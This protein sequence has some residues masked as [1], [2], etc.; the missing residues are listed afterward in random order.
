MSAFA[1]GAS[2]SIN[3]TIREVVGVRLGHVG[4]TGPLRSKLHG[5]LLREYDRLAE[6]WFRIGFRRGHKEARREFGRKGVVPKIL[7][8]KT[9]MKFSRG[10]SKAVRLVSV[11]K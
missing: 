10:A 7:H 6:I 11:L 3:K 5:K 2:A 4:P 9:T 8:A 1:S